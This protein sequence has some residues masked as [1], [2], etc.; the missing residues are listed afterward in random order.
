MQVNHPGSHFKEPEIFSAYNRRAA[1][2]TL[3]VIVLTNS[4]WPLS[5]PPGPFRQRWGM[6]GK[7][8]EERFP[9]TRLSAGYGFRKETI[10][11]MRR[12]VRDT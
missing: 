8:H 4:Q 10:T 5:H 3:F 2:F 11:G 9:P 12:K 6:A 7:G 1:I